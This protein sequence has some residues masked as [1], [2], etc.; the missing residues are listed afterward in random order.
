MYNSKKHTSLSISKEETSESESDMIDDL[1]DEMLQYIL[2][3][4]GT[5]EA[6][7]TSLLLKK[8][9]M[10]LWTSL[11]SLN[12]NPNEFVAMDEHQ[13]NFYESESLN[14]KFKGFVET[15]LCH[16]LEASFLDKFLVKFPEILSSDMFSNLFHTC[17]SYAMKHNARVFSME[18]TI[19]SEK[20]IACLFAWES[21]EEMCL[22]TTFY[23]LYSSQIIPAV[24]NLPRIRK[25]HLKRNK[26][27]SRSIS[28]LFAG[29]PKLEELSLENCNGE[30]S[31]IFSQKLKYL[32]LDCCTL[33]VSPN[34]ET[35]CITSSLHGDT[36]ESTIR[37]GSFRVKF[38]LKTRG[39]S[40]LNNPSSFMQ[41]FICCFD[42]DDP[43]SCLYETVT[44]LN[45]YRLNFKMLE[46]E[47]R[48]FREFHC[49]VELQLRGWCMIC[50]FSPVALFLEKSPNLQKLTLYNCELHCKGEKT[51]IH[52]IVDNFL[53]R[54]LS[55][56]KNLKVVHMKLWEDDIRSHKVEEASLPYRI[57]FKNIEIV[58][59][60]FTD[61]FRF[62][63][64]F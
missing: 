39:A 48:N 22:L 59:S 40:A 5:K 53:L 64:E 8:R 10:N 58:L 55:Q 20:L 56:C 1:P 9:W 41:N 23:F 31:R 15:V 2:S 62:L 24:V 12:F 45:L 37:T 38:I 18:A 63:R 51:G 19:H 21:I 44:T 43:L 35:V 11:P 7:Q 57:E 25:L 60:Q 6:V 32:S 50:N 54:E 49:L 13:L 26:L 4:L 29:C 30:F 28:R 42:L 27:D 33:E 34:K 36:V 61:R 3:F 52:Q 17:A 46:K 14:E 16:Q 47:L